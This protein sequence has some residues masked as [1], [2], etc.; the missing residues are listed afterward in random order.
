MNEIGSLAS[1]L[2]NTNK[3]IS[4]SDADW[5]FI[6]E[7][8]YFKF[9]KD[10][11]FYPVV[12][13]Q[14]FLYIKDFVIVEANTIKIP[15]N[16]N[17]NLSVYDTLTISYKE[18]ELLTIFTV[19]DKGRDYKNGEL[20]TVN[21]GVLSARLDSGATQPAQLLVLEV[22]EHGGINKLKI[23]NKGLYLQLPEKD[24]QVLGGSGT[25]AIINLE[26]KLLDSRTLVEREVTEIRMNDSSTELKLNYLL[27]ANLKEGKLSVKKWAL[28]LVGNYLQGTKVCEKFD[29]VR[30]FTLNLGL[31]LAA[32]NSFS[33]PSI[34]NAAMIR[35][36]TE[37]AEI[38]KR[39]T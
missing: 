5:S 22:D 3:V 26:F 29:V 17:I 4:Q 30:D 21:G 38:K 13:V 1:I 39:L 6:R 28:N 20:L 24:S 14:E 16:V 15:E 18:Y 8:A 36:D 35:L 9:N 34:F 25:G 37:I 10:G 11:V 23:E 32:K 2:N 27:P 31:P 19:K 33:M 12:S 7:G